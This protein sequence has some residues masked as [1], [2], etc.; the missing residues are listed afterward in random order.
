MYVL[1]YQTIENNSISYQRANLFND[2]RS[3]QKQ[4]DEEYDNTFNNLDYDRITWH[5]KFPVSATLKSDGT[6]YDWSILL[7]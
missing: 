4:M 1:I 3:A 6:T 7:V 5:T 2:W